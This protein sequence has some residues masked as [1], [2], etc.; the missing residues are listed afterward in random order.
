MTAHSNF[1]FADA[2]TR[3]HHVCAKRPA[4]VDGGK[5]AASSRQFFAGSLG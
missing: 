1:A 4:T 2:G 5:N 3:F